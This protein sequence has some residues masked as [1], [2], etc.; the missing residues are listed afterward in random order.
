MASLVQSSNR[1]ISV[2]NV[3]SVLPKRCRNLSLK[4]LKIRPSISWSRSGFYGKGIVVAGSEAIPE[5]APTRVF[6]VNAQVRQHCML[7]FIP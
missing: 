7:L 6:S 5:R 4:P 3:V 2:Q 1:A